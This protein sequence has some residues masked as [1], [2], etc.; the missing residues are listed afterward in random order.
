M[1]VRFSRRYSVIKKYL[2]TKA[3]VS[4]VFCA[5]ICHAS[6]TH[7]LPKLVNGAKIKLTGTVNIERRG[8]RLFLTV[9]TGEPY[10]AIF[11][12][13][14][15]RRQVHE[16]GLSLVGQESVLKR[17]VGQRVFVS[18]TLQLEP[19]S[20]YYFNGT[21]ILA[22][23][24][25]LPNGFVLVPKAEALAKEFP[26]DFKQFHALV[27]FSPKSAHFSYKI[28]GPDGRLLFPVTGYVSCGLNGPGDVMN[29]FCANGFTF[30]RVGRMNGDKFIMIGRPEMEFAQFGISENLREPVSRVIEC[31][32]K[33]VQ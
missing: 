10:V 27:K 16:I 12:G 25:Q 11:D 23:S 33:A 31:T 3:F 13:T 14:T 18:G 24:V 28:W 32:K 19:V 4:F 30:T 9:K 6:Q 5:L 29:C 2:L 17:Y 21:L 1:H 7:C 15:D 22:T 20:P 8:N 26:N